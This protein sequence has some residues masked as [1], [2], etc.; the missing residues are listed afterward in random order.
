L[1][2]LLLLPHQGGKGRKETQIIELPDVGNVP[3][4]HA[5]AFHEIAAYVEYIAGSRLISCVP[6]RLSCRFAFGVGV[7]AGK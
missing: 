4:L 6:K 7:L 5:S 2:P 3:A 1:R